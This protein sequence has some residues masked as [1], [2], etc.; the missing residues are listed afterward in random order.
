MI[1]YVFGFITALTVMVI[2][3]IISDQLFEIPKFLTGWFSCM[4]FYIA[5][6]LSE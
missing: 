5:K 1:K 3:S 4:G 2:V 6:E